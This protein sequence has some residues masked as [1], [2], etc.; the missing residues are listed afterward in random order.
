[1][2]ADPIIVRNLLVARIDTALNLVFV[3]GQVPGPAKGFIRVWDA[4]AKL[5]DLSVSW[6]KK[7]MGRESGDLVPHVKALPFPCGDAELARTL[8][9]EITF[10]SK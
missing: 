5:R 9:T 4:Q 10:G 3:K 2:G 8:P 6:E 7:G 1:M